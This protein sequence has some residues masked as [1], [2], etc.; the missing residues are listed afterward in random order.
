MRTEPLKTGCGQMTSAF[1]ETIMLKNSHWC[2]RRGLKHEWH[3]QRQST[4]SRA[5]SNNYANKCLL[6]RSQPIR[7]GQEVRHGETVT[8]DYRWLHKERRS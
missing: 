5:G 1:L 3:A 7:N 2:F 4:N 6:H 8:D